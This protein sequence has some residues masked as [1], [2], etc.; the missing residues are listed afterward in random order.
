MQTTVE[1]S[2]NVFDELDANG[3][4]RNVYQYML[5]LGSQAVG[6]LVLGMDFNHFTSPGAPM[7]RMVVLI[8]EMLELNKKV[9]SYSSWYASLP[10]GDP[11]KLRQVR[12]EIDELLEGSLRDMIG[13]GTHDLDL[14]EAAL[15]A[16]CIAGKSPMADP[17]FGRLSKGLNSD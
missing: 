17:I 5:K 13:S 11:K 12:A 8:S 6:K 7:H 4:A 15:S 14:Q 9:T 16:S 2:F 1:Q 3:E 10:F